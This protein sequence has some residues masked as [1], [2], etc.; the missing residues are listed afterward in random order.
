M[1]VHW[2]ALFMFISLALAESEQGIIIS[3]RPSNAD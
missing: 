3:T 1:E 2:N